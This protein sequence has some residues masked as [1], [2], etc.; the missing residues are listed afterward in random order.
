V[1]QRNS[2]IANPHLRAICDQTY[3]FLKGTYPPSTTTGIGEVP[4]GGPTGFELGDNYPNPFNP[5]TV[6][7]VG[8]AKGG[9]MSLKIYDTLGQLVKVV[10]EGYRSRGE[11]TYDVSMNNLASGVYFYTLREGPESMTRKMLLL[12]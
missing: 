12:R 1:S 7:D 6:I 9:V 2:Y 4:T 5:S 11:Y 8:L 3:T 10:D